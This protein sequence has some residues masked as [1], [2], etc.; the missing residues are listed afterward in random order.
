MKLTKKP[1]PAGA[2]TVC[3]GLTKHHERL[4]QRCEHFV[5]GRRCSGTY[6]SD[7][8][9]LWD[10]CDSCQATGKVGSQDCTECEGFGWKL[11]A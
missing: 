7:M 2:C 1:K 5:N 10:E 11:Y 6:H 9:I 3:R 8:S 4:N